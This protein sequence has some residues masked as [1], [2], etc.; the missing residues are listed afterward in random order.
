MSGLNRR[1]FIQVSAA[2]LLLDGVKALCVADDPHKGTD[3][4][5]AFVHTN[6]EGKSWTIGNAFVERE[7]RFDPKLGLYTASWRHKVTGTDFMEAARKRGVRD[8]SFQSW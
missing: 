8:T 5:T 6:A 2:S 1:A 3:T 7:I 4:A